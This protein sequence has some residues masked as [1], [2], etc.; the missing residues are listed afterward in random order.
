MMEIGTCPMCGHEWRGKPEAFCPS[1]GND[2]QPVGQQQDAQRT[3]T[4]YLHFVLELIL[5]LED[6]FG[7][8]FSEDEA[9]ACTKDS[10]RVG[11]IVSK[12]RAKQLAQISGHY[13]ETFFENLIFQVI[14]NSF[15][16]F[17]TSDISS[18]MPLRACYDLYT[19]KSVNHFH[20]SNDETLQLLITPQSAHWHYLGFKVVRLKAGE[21][22]RVSNPNEELAF[23]PLQGAVTFAVN[24][25]TFSVSRKNVFEELPHV[26]YLP[27][28]HE[29]TLKAESSLEIAWGSAPA[30]GKYPVRLFRP[31]EM[32][33]EVR[34]GGAAKRQVNHILSHPLPAERLI[35]FEVYV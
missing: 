18:T 19:K 32:K 27:P 13:E 5:K 25:Q 9:E 3:E 14:A 31:E 1:C 7:L 11:D 24:N 22:I 34:G 8:E 16:S 4:N 17:D 12:A 20:S 29:V 15:E 28:Q 35:L 10:T 30:T 2:L 33:K 26:L 23:V 6:T 21:Q